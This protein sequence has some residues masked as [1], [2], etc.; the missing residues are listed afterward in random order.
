MATWPGKKFVSIEENV[1]KIPDCSF[2]WEYEWAMLPDLS[3]GV[4]RGLLCGSALL[5]LLSQ[6]S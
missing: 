1:L 2:L 5:E 6:L 3:L 4:H